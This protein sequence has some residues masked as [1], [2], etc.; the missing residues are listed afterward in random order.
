M[1]LYQQM[2]VRS[3]LFYIKTF[4]NSTVA[5]VGNSAVSLFFR[6]IVSKKQKIIYLSLGVKLILK[7]SSPPPISCSWVI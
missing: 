2:S 6:K 7:T 5:K 3:N 4:K 1:R